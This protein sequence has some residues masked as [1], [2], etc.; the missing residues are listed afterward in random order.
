ML[1]LIAATGQCIRGVASSAVVKG[2]SSITSTVV[3]ILWNW[4]YEQC[5]QQYNKVAG[6]RM[7]VASSYKCF[8]RRPVK[9]ARIQL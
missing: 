2:L 7:M 9:Q 5:K 1:P 3:A 4:D 6:S 8:R